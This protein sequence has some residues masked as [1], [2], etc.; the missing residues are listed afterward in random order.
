ML[1]EPGFEWWKGDFRQKI[2]DKLFHRKGTMWAQ[3]QRCQRENVE[4]YKMAGWKEATTTIEE[5]REL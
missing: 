5:S 4:K 3:E 2:E 1:F